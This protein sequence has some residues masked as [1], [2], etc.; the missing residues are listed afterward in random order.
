MSQR[1]G[2]VPKTLKNCLNIDDVR[3]AAH[4]ALPL[5]IREYIDG[6]SDDEKTLVENTRTFDD[7]CLMPNFGT[8]IESADLSTT[9]LGQ[10]SDSP[11]LL[12]PWG[13]H[14]IMHTDGEVGTAK[15]AANTCCIYSMSNFSTTSMEDVAEASS[16]PK[17]L[18]IIRLKINAVPAPITRM[19]KA[20]NAYVAVCL[21][22]GSENSFLSLFFIRFIWLKIR[23][24]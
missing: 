6:G 14:K 23:T 22:S 12:S 1:A 18:A 19:T 2:I 7:V 9:I 21:L 10:K 8:G 13:A 20:N 4:K 17:F 16:A 24:T 5:A 15:A 11:I 3:K